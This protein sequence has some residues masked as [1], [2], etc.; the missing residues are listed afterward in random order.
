MSK[1]NVKQK[2][3]AQKNSFEYYLTVFLFI[4]ITPLTYSNKTLDPTVPRMLYWGISLFVITMIIYIYYKNK[5][6]DLG[7][8]KLWVFPV[9]FF[10]FLISIAS[11]TQA[12]NPAEGLYD[13]SKTFLT[14]FSVIII[15]LVFNQQADFKNFLVKAVILSSFLATALGLY[16]YIKLTHGNTGQEF[17][18]A[19]YQVRGLMAH[20]NQFAISLFLM[21]PFSTY[22]LLEF[23]N[24]WRYLSFVSVIALLISFVLIQTRSVWV[25]SIAFIIIF[26][27]TYLFS[28]HGKAFSRINIKSKKVLVPLLIVILSAAMSTLILFQKPNA[29]GVLKYQANSIF[30]FES[31]NNKGRLQI[32]GSTYKMSTEH[33]LL[34]V[35]SGNWKISIIPY[36]SDN[37]ENKYQNWRRPHNDFLWIMSEK[38]IF[39][40]LSYLLLFILIAFYGIKILRSQTD[41]ENK[42]FTRLMLAGIGG[43]FIIA[44]FSFP[45]ER[46]NHQIYLSLIM[47][48]II[49]IYYKSIVVSKA[50][51]TSFTIFKFSAPLTLLGFSVFYASV[52]FKSEIYINKYTEERKNKR[53]DW[54]KLS[55]YS[56]KAFSPFTTLD[57]KQIPIHIYKGVSK[58]KL[59]KKQASLNDFQIA[60]KYHPNSPA[61]INNLGYAYSQAGNYKKAISLFKESLEI[62]PENEDGIIN[63][64]N[65]YYL[66]KNY[67]EA[68]RTLQR[69]DRESDNPK[70]STLQ[71]AI[72]EKIKAKN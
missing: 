40:L 48:G 65:A 6:L 13:L 67:T 50:K 9:Y 36:Y 11:L 66:D 70:I 7:L 30:D 47:S 21:L 64:T 29:I 20:K 2:T 34:G 24:R 51:P 12:I 10:Y 18:M 46:I 35:G 1:K 33:M 54:N 57:S 62:F 39:G 14:L 68:R 52:F 49:S 27:L 43:Y 56:D 69:C 23:K 25:A 31:D 4:I 72:E 63:L 41:N 19:L 26:G 5:K 28:N 44:F 15:T 45:Y 59:G 71:K 38:G 3:I 16:Q 32:W 61:V 58:L 60:Y 55:D 8:L 42:L 22:G 53:P 37:F 17:F